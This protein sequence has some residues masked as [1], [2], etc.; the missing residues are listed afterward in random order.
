[1][2][3]LDCVARVRA[4]SASVDVQEAVLGRRAMDLLGNSEALRASG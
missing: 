3:N 1:M 4:I 2:G